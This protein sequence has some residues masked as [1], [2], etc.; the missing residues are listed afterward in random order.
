MAGGGPLGAI[1]WIGGPTSF[2]LETLPEELVG[3][4]LDYLPLKTLAR[5]GCLSARF[6][7]SYRNRLARRHGV[8]SQLVGHR[9]LDLWFLDEAQGI[10]P[11]HT[12]VPYDLI[13]DSQVRGPNM[14]SP[15]NFPLN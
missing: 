6:K 10:I 13:W 4:I 11:A 1:P 5:L 8:F 9:F 7:R 15:R 12:A 14:A 2:P 3:K